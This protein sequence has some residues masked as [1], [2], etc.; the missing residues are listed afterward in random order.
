MRKRRD[1]HL[2]EVWQ[3]GRV[4]T[5]RWLTDTELEAIR[6]MN[7]DVAIQKFGM[8]SLETTDENP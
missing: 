7:P 8:P 1:D 5:Y 2:Y 4:V 3:G 6:E